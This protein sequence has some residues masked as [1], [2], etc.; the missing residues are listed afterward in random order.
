MDDDARDGLLL[1]TDAPRAGLLRGV[2]E[3]VE[4][5]EGA[6]AVRA[7][8]G[9]RR[10][11]AV[12]LAEALGVE[13]W[14][15]LRQMLIEHGGRGLLLATTQGVRRDDLELAS[16]EGIDVLTLEPIAGGPGQVVPQAGVAES[17]GRLMQAPL[18]RYSPGYRSAADPFEALGPIGSLSI[19]S[20]G[21][22]EALSL[23]AR[24]AD[25]V[26]LAIALAGLPDQVDAVVCGALREPPEELRGLA[27][28]LT[29][30]LNVAG[31]TGATLHLC[32][33][34]AHQRRA[35]TV[36]GR[37]GM[38]R[39][40]DGGY[41]LYMRD[42]EPLEADEATEGRAPTLAALIAHQ[43]RAM[44]R[45]RAADPVDRRQVIACCQAILLAARTGQTEHTD[46]LMRL[47]P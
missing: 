41:R 38:L 36:V 27:G 7:V 10:S 9:P 6:S 14:D 46:K 42:A 26:D 5:G 34:V 24:L 33:R 13:P 28:H 21:P 4:R 29:A 30:S 1:W 23:F 3:L 15:D 44:A 16:E 19:T 20:V 11:D 18:M 12:E 37:E 17:R 39:L 2:A 22:V 25:A 43:W 47:T 35:A 31:R 8:G 32:D 45:R 40:T